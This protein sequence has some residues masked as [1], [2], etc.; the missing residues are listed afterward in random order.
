M[1][2]SQGYLS[3]H[4]SGLQEQDTADTIYRLSFILRDILTPHLQGYF[5]SSLF[6]LSLRS[7]VKNE[8]QELEA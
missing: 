4:Q 8:I 5:I 7:T 3:P 2:I 6:H 1:F